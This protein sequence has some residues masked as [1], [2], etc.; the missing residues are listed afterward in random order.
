MSPGECCGLLEGS[1]DGDIVRVM[2]LYPAHNLSNAD[3]RFEIAPK[4]HFFAQR[5]ARAAGNAIVGCYHSHPR[6]AACPSPAD[7]DGAGEEGL[8]WLITNQVALNA[9]VFL[10]G[11]F[12][13][14]ELVTHA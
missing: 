14:L 10:R 11:R 12:L 2:G 13:A 4:D 7:L 8:V 3:D 9:Y 5:H 1:R 6:G